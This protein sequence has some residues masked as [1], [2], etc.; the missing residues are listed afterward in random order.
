MHGVNRRAFALVVAF[1]LLIPGEV[2]AVNGPWAFTQDATKIRPSTAQL[3][4]MATPNGLSSTAWFEW[5]PQGSFSSTTLPVQVGDGFTVQYV[6][7][8]IDDLLPKGIYQCRL[9]VSNAAGV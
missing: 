6:R 3:N 7:T 8:D 1:V 5:G 2:L 4:G 9:I